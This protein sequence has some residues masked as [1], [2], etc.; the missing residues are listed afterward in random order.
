MKIDFSCLHYG[1]EKEEAL[2]TVSTQ[3]IEE[4][5]E[6]G[7][8]LDLVGTRLPGASDGTT[9]TPVARHPQRRQQDQ[10]GAAVA[11]A[12]GE[13][14]LYSRAG[15]VPGQLLPPFGFWAAPAGGASPKRTRKSEMGMEIGNRNSDRAAGGRAG[16]AAKHTPARLPRLCLLFGQRRAGPRAKC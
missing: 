12:V 9:T 5:G 4:G 2:H 3:C 15:L 10:Q 11:A 13:A 8:R 6:A 1:T 16:P 14:P 7:P